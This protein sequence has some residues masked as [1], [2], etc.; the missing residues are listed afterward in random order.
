MDWRT[1]ARSVKPPPASIRKGI[2]GWDV[3]PHYLARH[4][5]NLVV[6]LG[7]FATFAGV[8]I[9]AVLAVLYGRTGSASVSASVHLTPAGY[10]IA[11]R[12]SVKAVG[13]FRVKFSEK[14]GIVVRLVEIYVDNDQLKEGREWTDTSSFGHQYADAGE[15]LLTTVVFGPVQAALTVVGWTVFFRAAATT[16]LAVA[17]HSEGTT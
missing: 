17:C 8:V 14:A 12:P 7:A 15:E 5:L 4:G 11:A 9:G 2:A 16:R 1:G 10:V 3:L 13:L 6:G